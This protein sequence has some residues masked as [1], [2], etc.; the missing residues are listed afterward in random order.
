MHRLHLIQGRIWNERE[1]IE[2]DSNKNNGCEYY[3]NFTI[4]LVSAAYLYARN[5]SHTHTNITSHDSKY[6]SSMIFLLLHRFSAAFS[7]T[8]YK[9]SWLYF[10]FRGA[11]WNTFEIIREIMLLRRLC[12]YGFFFFSILYFPSF[13]FLCTYMGA[14]MRICNH[15]NDVHM[16]IHCLI[17][18]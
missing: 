14:V 15:S 17:L 5:A 18:L 4:A 7:F 9:I 6:R 13:L 10:S 16:I 11:K 2:G 8:R 1:S 12:V 3:C